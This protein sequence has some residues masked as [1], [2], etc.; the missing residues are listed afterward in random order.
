MHR[1]LNQTVKTA[2]N[3]SLSK[4][5]RHNTNKNSANS[6]FPFPLLPVLDELPRGAVQPVP[7]PHAHRI[8]LLL[9][10]IQHLPKSAGQGHACLNVRWR[11]PTMTV[12]LWRTLWQTE[13]R[14]SLFLVCGFSSL[15]LFTYTRYIPLTPPKKLAS[16]RR[17][18]KEKEYCDTRWAIYGMSRVELRIE[19]QR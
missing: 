13:G 5:A 8:E 18:K 1:K 16:R 17:K 19:T 6:P 10:S 4:T 9:G 11:G 3:K 12:Q 15:E 2:K 14:A 7:V